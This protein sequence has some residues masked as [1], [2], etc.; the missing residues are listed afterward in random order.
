MLA[1]TFM[2]NTI[3]ALVVFISICVLPTTAIWADAETLSAA[4][5]ADYRSAENR[6]RDNVRHPVATLAFF[7]IRNDMTVVEISP[8]GGWYTEILAPFLRDNGKLYAANYDPDS[9][10]EYY[11]SNAR[12]FLDKLAAD[13]AIYGQVIP[14]VFDPPAKL[15][16]APPGSADMVLTFRNLHNW[17]EEGSEVA[18]LS[19]MHT[20]LKP[21]GILG[22]VQ[23]RQDSSVEQD[24]QAASGYVREDYVIALIEAAGFKWVASSEINA[25]PKDTRNYSEGVWTL[26]PTYELGDQ[27]RDRYRAI[28]ESDRMT[29]K[30]IK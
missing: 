14:M 20:A 2:L 24:P 1:E 4:A 30:F 27:D 29:M 17:M 19:A 23:H 11:R 26:P 18:A 6:A 16:A 15:E 3:R 10:Q 5:E 25:N 7:G 22:I 13:P 8:G 21:G 28:G 9:K 12:L